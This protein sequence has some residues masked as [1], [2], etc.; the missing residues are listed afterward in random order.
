MVIQPL[1]AIEPPVVLITGASRG[2]GRAIALALDASSTPYRLVLVA[3]S[4]R[5]LQALAEEL[6]SPSLVLAVDLTDFEALSTIIPT[7]VQHFGRLDVLINNAGVGG[8]VG[9][10][11]ELPD[12]HLHRMINLNLTAPI[13][14][15]KQAIAQFVSQNSPGTLVQIN[16]IAGKTAFP[17]WAVYDATKAGLHAFSQAISEEQRHNGTR[18][19]SLYPGA[20]D[21]T[22]WDSVDLSADATPDREGML[23]PECVAEAVLF[24]LQQ[25]PHVLV[26]DITL[27]PTRPAL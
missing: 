16:S 15:S 26:S 23:T 1:N 8:K 11:N 18:V 10:V 2:I 13:A 24:A 20:S 27:M 14:L 19:I 5:D 17:F 25:P 21:T 9:L 7:A 12:A 6:Q 3:R 4:E 22:I